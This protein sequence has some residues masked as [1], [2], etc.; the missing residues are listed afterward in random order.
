MPEKCTKEKHFGASYCGQRYCQK[1]T[2]R[3]IKSSHCEWRD[4]HDG[5]ETDKSYQCL[6]NLVNEASIS[7]YNPGV[8]QI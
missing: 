7:D 6:R 3:C 8:N 5:R 4:Q 1:Y 2:D